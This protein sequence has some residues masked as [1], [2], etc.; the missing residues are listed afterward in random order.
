MQ[1]PEPKAKKYA[2]PDPSKK[3][4]CAEDRPIKLNPTGQYNLNFVDWNN[5]HEAILDADPYSYESP[6]HGMSNEVY[7]Q[8][9]EEEFCDEEQEVHNA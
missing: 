5:E 8:I 4:N 9:M 1:K 2:L 7:A 6:I 3:Q